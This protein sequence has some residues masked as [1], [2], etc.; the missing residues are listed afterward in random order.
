MLLFQ[1]SQ[2]WNGS[3]RLKPRCQQGWIPLEPPG[4]VLSLPFSPSGGRL[5]PAA[6]DPFLPSSK[7]AV[8][9]KP[10]LVSHRFD[11]VS[12]LLLLLHMRHWWF[13]GTRQMT[14]EISPPPG[15]LISHFHSICIS[16]SLPR[17]WA[18]PLVLG[19]RMWTS[20]GP[21]FASHIHPTALVLGSFVLPCGQ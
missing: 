1:G 9:A 15:Q 7:P 12:C 8:A 4:E 3:H 2:V 17:N 20:L 5:H 19:I 10:R 18:D 11:R 13:H 6:P 16:S 14:Q 21:L